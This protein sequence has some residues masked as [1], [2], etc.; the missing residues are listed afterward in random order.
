DQ[1]T[2][3]PFKEQFEHFHPETADASKPDHVYMDMMG[4]G[5]GCCCL[6]VTFQA[7]NLEE[8][9]SLYDQLAP[10]CPLIMALSAASPIHRGYLTDRD[11]RWAVVSQSVD[12]RTT[13]ELGEVPMKA[14]ECQTECDNKITGGERLRA[15]HFADSK[16]GQNV[17][18]NP[19]RTCGC[20]S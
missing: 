17:A 11:R 12:D 13:E 6:Q 15:T 5:M 10:L 19:V 2:P 1:N 9:R 16:R 7:S 14:C 4:F 20:G 3:E 18:Y 8:A